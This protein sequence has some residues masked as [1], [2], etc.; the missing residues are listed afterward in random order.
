MESRFENN[1]KHINAWREGNDPE[2]VYS[3]DPD[4]E[5]QFFTS[6]PKNPETCVRI[7]TKEAEE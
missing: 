5:E 1:Y 4:L 3:A 2:I 6:N 7:I